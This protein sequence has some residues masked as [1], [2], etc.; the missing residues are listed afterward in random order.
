MNN[1]YSEYLRGV[2]KEVIATHSAMCLGRNEDILKRRVSLCL[3]YHMCETIDAKK[4]GIYPGFLHLVKKKPPGRKW[5]CSEKSF[6]TVLTIAVPSNLRLKSRQ[7]SDGSV[8]D[9]T[10]LH[11]DCFDMHV[12][13]GKVL[14]AAATRFLCPLSVWPHG[15]N[16]I[17]LLFTFNLTLLIDWLRMGGQICLES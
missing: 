2:L 9:G 17:F 6:S 10:T 7:W 4:M 5:T 14:E 1:S 12:L 11:W 15:I 3:T 8:V 16:L 13:C